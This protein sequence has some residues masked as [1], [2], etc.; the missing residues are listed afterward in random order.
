MV[1]PRDTADKRIGGNSEMSKRLGIFI[2]W[3]AVGAQ[4]AAEGS[5]EQAVFF[6]GM[7]DEM[8]HWPTAYSREMQLVDVGRMLTNE[9]RVLL[10]MLG[11]EEN[12]K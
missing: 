10:S 8:F 7:C 9:H 12:K 1:R 3:E 11:A 4:L 6:K 2:D 5:D